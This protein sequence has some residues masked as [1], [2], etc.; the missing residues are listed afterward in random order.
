MNQIKNYCLRSIKSRSIKPI[1]NKNKNRIK[2]IK[3]KACRKTIKHNKPKPIQNL[4][5]IE[6]L[7]P[8]W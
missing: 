1:G 4:Q 6:N 5:N 3:L 2:T 7:K 8:I